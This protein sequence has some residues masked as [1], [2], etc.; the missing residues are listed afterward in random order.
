[1]DATKNTA[2]TVANAVA[3]MGLTILKAAPTGPRM[4]V[5]KKAQRDDD[6]ESFASNTSRV[7]QPTASFLQLSN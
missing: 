2:A 3:N 7:Y 1:M 4:V 5:K 6:F